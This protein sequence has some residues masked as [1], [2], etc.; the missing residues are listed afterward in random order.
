MK[1]N[2]I[3]VADIIAALTKEPGVYCG[4][5][6]TERG[7]KTLNAGFV[8]NL[9]NWLAG[10]L[11]ASAPTEP[12]VHVIRLDAKNVLDIVRTIRTEMERK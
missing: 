7:V 10:E 12:Q 1:F 5:V 8:A 4:Q 3:P 6:Q 9:I 11:E 2:D